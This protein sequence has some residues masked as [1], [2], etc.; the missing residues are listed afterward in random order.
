VSA[1]VLSAAPAPVPLLASIRTLGP[2]GPGARWCPCRAG[3][4]HLRNALYV[5]L[6]GQRG[7]QSPGRELGTGDLRDLRCVVALLPSL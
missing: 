7:P 2:E 5:V 4:C 6:R 1:S 3:R